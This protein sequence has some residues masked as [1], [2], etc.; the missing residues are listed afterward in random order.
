MV[1]TWSAI[2]APRKCTSTS[3]SLARA[4]LSARAIA[5]PAKETVR[6]IPFLGLVQV[7]AIEPALFRFG[8]VYRGVEARQDRCRAGDAEIRQQASDDERCAAI[9]ALEV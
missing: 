4:A 3:F 6:V 7:E 5:S 2:R 1:G 8:W 9:G